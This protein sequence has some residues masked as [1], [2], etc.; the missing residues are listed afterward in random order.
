MAEKQDCNNQLQ[1]NNKTIKTEYELIN[2]K[3]DSITQTCTKTYFNSILKELVKY[4]IEN[5]NII[6]DY[7]TAEENEINRI[8][9]LLAGNP[10]LGKSSFKKS[11]IF[12]KK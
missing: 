9:V 10:G 7:I 2:R 3:I 6:C 12:N 4:N 1:G 11:Y 8:N 5:A